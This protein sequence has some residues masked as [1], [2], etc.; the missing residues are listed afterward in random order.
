MSDRIEQLK[1][2]VKNS[3]NIHIDSQWLNYSGIEEYFSEELVITVKAGTTIKEIQAQL[4]ENV[5]L[6]CQVFHQ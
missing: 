6:L 1:E 3:S 2:E 5:Y 4:E